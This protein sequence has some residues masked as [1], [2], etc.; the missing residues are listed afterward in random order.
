[1]TRP[2]TKALSAFVD[3][4]GQWLMGVAYSLT[5]NTHEAEDLAQ[6][7]MGQLVRHWTRV[8]AADNPRAYVRRI[9]SNQ[10]IRS[11]RAR[12]RH[13]AALHDEPD[14]QQAGGPTAFD[15]V[16]D[17]DAIARALRS[18]PPSQQTAVVLRFLEDCTYRDV[19]RSIG[20]RE[21]TA[22]SLVHRALKTLRNEMAFMTIDEG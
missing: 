15:G 10:Y 18:L 9:L 4:H 21:V 17:R 13:L 1:M 20:C 8:S 3:E 19:A 11:R 12:P 6:D 2:D 5:L 14:P 22:R 16:E 7:V